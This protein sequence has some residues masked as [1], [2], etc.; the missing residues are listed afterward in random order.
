MAG[1]APAARAGR[2]LER[3]EAGVRAPLLHLAVEDHYVDVVTARGHRLLLI[4]FAD[5]LAEIEPDEGMQVHRSHWVA[6]R[7]V[8]KLLSENGRL[9]ILLS[10]GRRVPVSRPYVAEARARF[11]DRIDR[12]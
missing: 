3:L 6:D 12:S 2:L 7:A 8:E 5:A 4:R 1:G 11:S 9:T 10:T